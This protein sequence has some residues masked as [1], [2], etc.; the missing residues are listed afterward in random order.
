MTF[1]FHKLINYRNLRLINPQC[2]LLLRLNYSEDSLISPK[3]IDETRTRFDTSVDDR[4]NEIRKPCTKLVKAAV[5]GSPNA[6]KSTLINSIVGRR[7]FPV[8]T[9]VHTSQCRARAVYNVDDTQIVFLDTPGLVAADET[10]RH[11]LP[12]SF[13]RDGEA[14]VA[15]ADIVTIVHDVTNRLKDRLDKKVL[16]LLYL[17]HNKK[18]VLIMNKVDCIKKKKELLTLCDKLTCKTLGN[19]STCL[20]INEKL[21][22]ITVQKRIENIKGWPGFEKVFMVSALEGSGVSDIMEYLMKSAKPAHW[23]FPSSTYTDQEPRR[24]FEEAVRSKLL[25]YLPQ[26]VPY[27]LSV[28]L[29][30]FETLLDGTFM[31]VI[32]VGCATK[33]LERLVMGKGGS[34]IKA[35]AKEAEK[36]LQNTFHTSVHLKVVV[37]DKS[38]V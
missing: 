33:R 7:I 14:A 28:S 12:T 8:S 24:I 11:H 15:E 3:K 27:N 10:V 26:E 4:S 20:D 38:R 2:V 30:Y 25:D 13:L 16:R 32:L 5:I 31:V 23:L 17:Y 19:I 18:T 6:G 35:V 1:R 37:T 34:R 22:E 21:T 29:E 36:D 9:K